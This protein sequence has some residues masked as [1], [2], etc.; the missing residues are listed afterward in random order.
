MAE[1]F[2]ELSVV[3]AAG[4]A[5]IAT[6]CSKALLSLLVVLLAIGSVLE[7]I[8]GGVYQQKQILCVWLLV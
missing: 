4:A 8:G 5:G 6:A 2:A 1:L 3:A 7:A